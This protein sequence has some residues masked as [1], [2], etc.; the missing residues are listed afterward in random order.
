[1]AD[2]D[3][4]VPLR[5]YEQRLR[6]TPNGTQFSNQ[7]TKEDREHVDKLHNQKMAR[8][9]ADAREKKVDEAFNERAR[10]KFTA[11]TKFK[12]AAKKDRGDFER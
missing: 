6:F 7:V 4:K 3:K 2:D 1:M 8:E 10:M 11:K 12:R 9:A 5:L